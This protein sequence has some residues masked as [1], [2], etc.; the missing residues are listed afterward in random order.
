MNVF[1][2][3]WVGVRGFDRVCMLEFRVSKVWS[4][5]FDG[6]ELECVCLLYHAL[7]I[8]D[9]YF[10]LGLFCSTQLYCFRGTSDRFDEQSESRDD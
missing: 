4:N 1:I 3:K 7:R 9:R 8:R 2:F 10:C 5:D 6:T